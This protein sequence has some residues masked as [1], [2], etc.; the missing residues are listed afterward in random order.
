MT[1]LETGAQRVDHADI[2]IVPSPSG[3]P[4]QYLVSREVGST[5]LFVA[6]QWLQPGECVLLHTHPVEESITFLSGKGEATLGARIVEIGAGMSLFIPA[7][8]IHG[9]RCTA[10]TLHVIFAFPIAEFAE[11][12]MVEPPPAHE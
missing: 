1:N 7:G 11:T 6:Q 3:L 10:G 8:A 2:P 5:S 4:T 9:F 12:I